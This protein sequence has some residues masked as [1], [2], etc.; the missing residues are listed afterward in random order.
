MTRREFLR[1]GA[2][3]AGIAPT[4]LGSSPARASSYDKYSAALRRPL[5]PDG[6]IE[7]VIRFATL[8][9]NGHNTQSWQFSTAGD[10]IG[11]RPDLSRRTPVVDPDDHHIY[12]SL[13]CAAENLALAASATGRTGEVVV[14][15]NGFVSYAWKQGRIVRSPLVDVIPSRQSTRSIFAGQPASASDLKQLEAASAEHGVRVAIVTDSNEISRLRDLVVAGNRRQLADPAFVAELKFWIRFSASSA[16]ESG[17][18]LYAPVTGNPSM[19]EFIGRIGFSLFFDAAAEDDKCAAQMSSSAGV[20]IFLGDHASPKHWAKVGRAAERFMLT[21]TKLGLATSF[22]NQP[23]EV[24]EL[25]SEL[26]ALAGEPDLRPDLLIRFGRAA[27]MPYS[28]RRPV[29]SVMLPA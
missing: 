5:D 14:E 17:D 16:I 22:L 9:P 3:S 26:A 7:E 11:I 18:G 27:P 20:A 10:E 21:A 19:P 25:R 1:F 12:V 29:G 2:L 24:P 8:A 4:I 15:D 28:P 13:G 23:V 6:G